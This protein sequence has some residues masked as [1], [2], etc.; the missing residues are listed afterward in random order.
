MCR[1]FNKGKCQPGSSTY[2]SIFAIDV[3]VST[4]PPAAT[5]SSCPSSD[6]TDSNM[7]PL[8]KR[9]LNVSFFR[10]ELADLLN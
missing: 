7:P 3:A 4:L 5:D 2:T 9:K 10:K 8:V 1:N 6:F